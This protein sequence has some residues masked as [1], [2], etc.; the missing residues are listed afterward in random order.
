M[1]G[2]WKTSPLNRSEQL[3][4]ARQ[5]HEG[6]F[7]SAFGLT[8]PLGVGFIVRGMQDRPPSVS[9]RPR[10]S[11]HPARWIACNPVDSLSSPAITV[12]L[13]AF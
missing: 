2:C 8:L 1:S 11:P 10:P 13:T 12:A 9:D 4:N 6:M 7:L 5:R 3:T